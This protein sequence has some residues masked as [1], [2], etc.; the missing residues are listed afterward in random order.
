EQTGSWFMKPA[1]TD[2]SSFHAPHIER[3]KAQLRAGLRP[4]AIANSF[5]AEGLGAIELVLIFREATGA[6]LADIKAFGQWW[7]PQGVTDPEA[8]DG[9]AFEVLGKLRPDSR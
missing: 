8:F 2:P 4:S 7:G 3:V 6:S 1:T 5:H 9:W